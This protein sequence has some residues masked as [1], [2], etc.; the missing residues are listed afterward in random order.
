MTLETPIVVGEITLERWIEGHTYEDSL[1]RTYYSGATEPSQEDAEDC[2]ANPR[3][4]VR[5]LTAA[6]AEALLDAILD[7]WA[8][9]WGYVSAA[10]CITYVGD[11][12]ETFDAEGVAMRNAR[13]A[14]WV[15]VRSADGNPETPPL[16]EPNVRAFAAPFEP[17]RPTP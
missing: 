16:T 6:E 4:F 9:A 11:P 2:L 12:D 14:L 10:R 5:V 3:A 7:G 8:K 1:G 15:A 17:V 13:S